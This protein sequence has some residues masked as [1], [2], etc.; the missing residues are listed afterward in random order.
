MDEDLA[1]AQDCNKKRL[2]LLI[3]WNGDLKIQYIWRKVHFPNEMSRKL[4]YKHFLT[5]RHAR[6]SLRRGR[7]W[8]TRMV[9]RRSWGPAGGTSAAGSAASAPP[10]APAPGASS[11]NRMSCCGPLWIDMSE[12]RNQQSLTLDSFTLD[13]YFW[14]IVL[15]LAIS[16]LKA[17]ISFCCVQCFEWVGCT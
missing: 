1:E 13:S 5:L 14:F 3:F 10:P 15:I 11:S 4:E 12:N 7:C 2:I 9:S 16:Q 6:R 8:W 17:C